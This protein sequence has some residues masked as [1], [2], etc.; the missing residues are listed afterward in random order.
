MQRIEKS[1]KPHRGT[2]LRGTK[3]QDLPLANWQAQVAFSKYSYSWK[4]TVITKWLA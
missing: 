4:R 1:A 3:S 2:F